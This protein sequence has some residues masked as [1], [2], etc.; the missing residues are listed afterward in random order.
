MLQGLV[1][2]T[3]QRQEMKCPCKFSR[4]TIFLQCFLCSCCAQI[5]SFDFLIMKCY[6]IY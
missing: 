6:R 1:S 4:V 2:N 3:L 5:I